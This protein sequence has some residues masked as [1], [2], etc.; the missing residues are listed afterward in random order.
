MSDPPATPDATPVPES[1]GPGGAPGAGRRGWVRTLGRVGCLTL[2]GV[3]AVALV[4]LAGLW[5]F[6]QTQMGN[7]VI[8][9]L[10]EGQV[11]G[12]MAEGSFSVGRLDTNLR[13]YAAIEDLRIDDAQGTPV[14]SVRSARVG[15][16][17]LQLLRGRMVLPTVDVDGL[18]LDLENDE[19]GMVIARLFASGA[20]PSDEPWTGIGVDLSAPLVHAT[21]ATVTYRQ[22]DRRFTVSGIDLTA[23]VDITGPDVAVQDIVLAGQMTEPMLAP[24]RVDGTITYN[25][26][27]VGLHKA[28]ITLADSDVT[29]SG[30]LNGLESDIGADVRLHV[31]ELDLQGLD[32][33]LGGA[34]IAGSYGG[35]LHA[36]GALTDLNI[37]GGLAGRPGT[38]GAVQVGVNVDV[39]ASDFPWRGSLA[40]DGFDVNDVY[41]QLEQTVVIGGTF[42]GEGHGIEWPRGVYATGVFEADRVQ[43]L[44]YTIGDSTLPLTLD[45]GVL[46]IDAGRV[47]ADYGA[48]DVGGTVDLAEGDI[49]VAAGGQIDVSE[50]GEFGV[51]DLAGKG[52]IDA[53]VSGNFM[54]EGLPIHVS[55]SIDLRPFAYAADVAFDRLFAR[56][57]VDVL[58]L[59]V[60][61]VANGRAEQGLAYGVDVGDVRLPTLNVHV[62]KQLDVTVDGLAD[63]S[64]IGMPDLF[65]VE[66]VA[67]PFSAGLER[68]EG[69]EPSF[70]TQLQ[71]GDLR[72]RHLHAD[73]GAVD[74]A[75]AEGNLDFGVELYEARRKFLLTDG[76]MEVAPQK[77]RIEKLMAAPTKDARWDA[78]GPQWFT[79]TDGGVTDAHIDLRGGK[80]DIA[81]DGAIGTEGQLDA[82]FKLAGVDLASIDSLAQLEQELG[83]TLSI[84]GGVHGPADAFDFDAVVVGTG[85][86][87]ASLYEPIDVKGTLTGE[88]GRVNT[89]LAVRLRGEPLFSAKGFFPAKLDLGAPGLDPG[90]RMDL[91]VVVRPG[92]LERF[93][94][95]AGPEVAIPEG[96]VSAVVKA[97][98]FLY[99]PNILASGVLHGKVDGWQE[100]GR[101]EFDVVRRG[102]GVT[103]WANLYE[104]LTY[105][106]ASAGGGTTRVHELIDWGLGHG[107]EPD[108]ADYSLFIDNM[109]GTLALKDAPAKQLAIA[110]GQDLDIA[111]LIDAVL[112]V[113]GSP[114]EPVVGL[115]GEW[116][117]ARLGTARVG[118]ATIDLQPIDEAYA[119]TADIR[120]P[121]APGREKGPD[122]KLLVRGR[123]PVT[124]RLQQDFEAWESGDYDLVV[125]GVDVPLKLAS[126][127]DPGVREA[128][129]LV[130][131][132]GEVKGKLLDPRPD[133]DVVVINGRLAYQ[134]LG[135]L[136]SDIHM[137]ANLSH[138]YARLKR[139]DLRTERLR[140]SDVE[141]LTALGEGL[142]STAVGAGEQLL[143]GREI[144]R[145]T[146]VAV[147]GTVKLD[148][149][150]PTTVGGQVRLDQALLI[151]TDDFQVKV[152][153]TRD[154]Q[155]AQAV[156]ISG[157][158]PELV[159]DGAVVADDVSIVRDAASFRDAAPLELDR[160][161]RVVRTG[162][163]QRDEAPEEPEPALYE[164]FKVAVD[165][166][167]ERNVDARVVMPFV[168]D[169]GELLS[170]ISRT[171][172]EARVGGDL[173]AAVQGGEIVLLGEVEVIDGEVSLLYQ[174]LGLDSG[175]IF[176]AGSDYLEPDLDLRA[177]TDVQGADLQVAIGGRPSVPT[178]ELS[179]SDYPD[180]SSVL[181]ML[182]TNKR[183]EELGAEGSDFS[184]SV[185]SL[186]SSTLLSGTTLGGGGMLKPSVDADGTM[187]LSGS[188][189]QSVYY[190]MAERSLNSD[191]DE[192]RREV[193]VELSAPP[194]FPQLFDGVLIEGMGGTQEISAGVSFQWRPP[195]DRK[196][197]RAKRKAAKAKKKAAELKAANGKTK[198]EDP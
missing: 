32:P 37:T 79:L 184:Q 71:V 121:K 88:R 118:S 87:Q 127:A 163:E 138:R 162:V 130:Q 9:G 124:L 105:R 53:V 1:A 4:G 147:N 25:G 171:T 122:P 38:D 178:I 93:T 30:M 85:I 195:N 160:S 80:G 27:E 166:D 132:D 86:E 117:Q 7:E 77:V 46:T 57:K 145:R 141:Q 45:E 157:T 111:G 29:V 128:A 150:K 12:L 146:N 192:N 62:T 131:I 5:M 91:S 43:I 20:P 11:N 115:S 107:P 114:N 99:N 14:V 164:K 33:L 155:T 110:G 16:K 84:E 108:L 129:G 24:L 3:P 123:L 142:V 185:I 106:G 135:I 39:T 102:G 172:V 170:S 103:W 44:D 197:A 143:S 140:S 165:I 190:E 92:A 101:A 113:E 89:D 26:D 191:P 78:Q 58:D 177:S 161:L 119:L 158:W 94:A 174:K 50:L 19:Q 95:F 51:T 148:D 13:S 23:G 183:P 66:R 144:G 175:T 64:G 6:G 72:V 149:W 63:A 49:A 100:V 36:T 126:L 186:L 137:D 154:T 74:L 47:T 40:L 59:V 151:H 116:K 198:E 68:R 82:T 153:G 168:D 8:R 83:G 187:R 31:S 159:V 120:F 176:F 193:R 61:V 96:A 134:P 196:A 42:S 139:L 56:Y 73:D 189:G 81:L 52:R 65:T 55:G 109:D 104:G 41:P 156:A 98:G 75:M 10:A 97:D 70:S 48:F 18:V 136:Y 67:G 112:R 152:S 17:P 28:H 15:V 167:L 21:D 90:S 179:S 188:L 2:A 76:R 194:N 34:G 173:K 182:I 180:E 125:K 181:T 169:F 69:A 133:I 60:D 35:D 22:G 54:A